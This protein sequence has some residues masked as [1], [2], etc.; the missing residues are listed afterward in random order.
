MDKWIFLEIT[1]VFSQYGR[2]SLDGVI[3]KGKRHPLPPDVHTRSQFLE[4]YVKLGW[5]L[6]KSYSDV[7]TFKRI[8]KK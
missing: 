2:H 7:Y 4:Y 6:V 8:V 1:L 3:V 5:I